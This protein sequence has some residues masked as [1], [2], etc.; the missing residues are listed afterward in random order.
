MSNQMKEPMK[1]SNNKMHNT[2]QEH[3]SALFCYEISNYK[4]LSNNSHKYVKVIENYVNLYY[5]KYH[6]NIQ[7]KKE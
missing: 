6:K 7:F 2:N 5:N 1:L 4:Q 3:I